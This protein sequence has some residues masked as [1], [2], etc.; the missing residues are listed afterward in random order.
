MKTLEEIRKLIKNNKTQIEKEHGVKIIGIFGSYARGEATENSD[1]DLL[2]EFEKINGF[3]TLN[4][5]DYFEELI[6]I[7]VDL[8]SVKYIKPRLLS[9]IQEDLINV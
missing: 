7:K 5:W 4:I 8:I 3:E 1:L 9:L 2:V 6:G